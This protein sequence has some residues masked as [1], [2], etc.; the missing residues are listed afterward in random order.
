[1]LPLGVSVRLILF[2]IPNLIWKIISI[3]LCFKLI[4]LVSSVLPIFYSVSISPFQLRLFPPPL[5][6]YT[7]Y[8]MTKA[9][10][11]FKAVQNLCCAPAERLLACLL[12]ILILI[13]NNHENINENNGEVVF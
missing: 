2:Q 6:I 7:S 1:M 10:K 9:A 8:K 13:I 5:S 4:L 12:F 11:K 3:Y